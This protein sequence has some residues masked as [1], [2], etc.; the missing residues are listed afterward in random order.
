M[1]K[2]DKHFDEITA[3]DHL[4]TIS[5][6]FP[7]F[8]RHKKIATL[9]LFYL[10]AVGNVALAVAMVSKGEW[11]FI[12]VFAALTIAIPCFGHKIVEDGIERAKSL[13]IS[14]RG[15]AL[16]PSKCLPWE[17]IKSWDFSE[18]SGARSF[19]SSAARKGHSIKLYTG[20]FGFGQGP[21]EGGKGRSLFAVRGYFL[22]EE[23][24]VIWERIATAKGIPRNAN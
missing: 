11:P 14:E 5:S 22:D 21:F 1:K 16:S 6:S 18:Y 17:E 8:T 23:Q 13:I 19:W 10:L 9:L 7:P 24:C 20:L 15:V 2:N 3:A 4:L 12:I